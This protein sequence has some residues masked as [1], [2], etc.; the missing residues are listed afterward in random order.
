MSTRK[1]SPLELEMT[2]RRVVR[3]SPRASKKSRF[4][5]HRYNYTY[6]RYSRLASPRTRQKKSPLARDERGCC[7]PT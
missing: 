3:L 6:M 2:V 5:P 1:I 7:R 4:T